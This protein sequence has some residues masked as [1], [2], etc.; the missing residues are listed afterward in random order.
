MQRREAELE[1]S[2]ED[3]RR[4]AE[5]VRKNKDKVDEIQKRELEKVEALF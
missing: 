4:Q 5:M 1:V 3:R 2:E